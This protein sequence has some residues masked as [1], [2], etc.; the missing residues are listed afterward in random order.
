M[1]K[2]VNKIGG[3]WRALHRRRSS[4]HHS[5]SKINRVDVNTSSLV[6]VEV[7]KLPVQVGPGFRYSLESRFQSSGK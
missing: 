2:G 6:C 3:N 4:L 7:R 1:E 5:M